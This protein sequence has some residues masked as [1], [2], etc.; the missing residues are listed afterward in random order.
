[1]V[2]T[3]LL[4]RTL[5]EIRDHE[6][7]WDQ[8]QWVNLVDDTDPSCGTTLCFAG[9]AACLSGAEFV[10][11][12]EFDRTIYPG[13]FYQPD[14]VVKDGDEQHVE[15]YAQNVLGLDATQTHALFHNMTDDVDELAEVVDQIIDGTISDEADAY[16]DEDWL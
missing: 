4:H 7:K 8:G 5:D 15:T 11:V 12:E 13:R 3:D 2:N 1:M 9:F 16:V 6:D 14:R 10:P